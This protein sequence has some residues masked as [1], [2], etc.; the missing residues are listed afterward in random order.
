MIRRPPSSTRTD[1]LFPYTAL[2]RSPDA[3]TAHGLSRMYV[4]GVRRIA[5]PAAPGGAV[6][7]GLLHRRQR[8]GGRR[9]V[10]D[11]LEWLRLRIGG[12]RFGYCRGR[13]PGRSEEHTS[14]LLSLMRISYAVFCLKKTK[15]QVR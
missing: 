9:V 10:L 15:T 11:G 13:L 3:E 12:Q 14:E 6:R 7:R 8:L 2:C 1:A 4:G 5:Q